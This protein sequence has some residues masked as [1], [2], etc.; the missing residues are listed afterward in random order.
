ML[1]I[2][3]AAGPGIGRLADRIGWQRLALSALA[4]GALG[5]V[6]SLPA[7]LPTLVAGLAMVTLAN[8]AGVTAAQLGVISAAAADRGAA[9]AV[10]FSLYYAVGSLGAYLPGLAWERYRWDGVVVTGFAALAVAGAV[11]L[12]GGALRPS[13]RAR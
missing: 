9:S 6:L 7:R 5:L 3:G 2:L 12:L 1:W 10:Y 4:L 8:F 13:P 11:L